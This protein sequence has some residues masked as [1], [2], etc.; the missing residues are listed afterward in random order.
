MDGNECC[1]LAFLLSGVR[2]EVY[3]IG[4]L[5]LF[6][7]VALNLSLILSL[8]ADRPKLIGPR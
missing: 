4:I 7:V 6:M 1:L 8:T 2:S 5:R 3:D